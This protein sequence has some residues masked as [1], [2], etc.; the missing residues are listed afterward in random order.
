[1]NTQSFDPSQYKDGQRKEWDEA[2]AGWKK[3]WSA[4]ERSMQP[5]SDRLVELAEIGQGQRVLDI[6]TGIGEPAVTAARRV[7]PTGRVVA[8][9]LSHQMLEIAAE[10]VAAAGFS[11]IEFR[12]SDAEALD[13]PENSFDAVLCRF[14]LMFLSDVDS[15]LEKVLRLLVPGGRFAAAVWGPPEKVPM[16]SIPMGV[17]RHELQLP[18]PMPGTPG[19]F[20]LADA[21]RLEEKVEGA[22]FSK[23]RTERLAVTLEMASVEEF[24][25]F[26]LD[27]SAPIRAMVADQTPERQEEI[28]R[29]IAAA[30]RP[31]VAADGT[32]R[33]ENEA[34][35]V[36]GQR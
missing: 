27:I 18:Q 6:A 5:V 30:M 14:G 24:V 28:R 29:A 15:A 1:M 23:V 22:G 26:R 12:E 19:L 21:G 17:I 2:A 20:S 32:V 16:S 8:T 11:N 3:W 25:R 7:G 36:V 35:L 34:I 13:L 4:F 9:D 10:R 31:Y 33:V